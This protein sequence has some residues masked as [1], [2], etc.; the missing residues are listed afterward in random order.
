MPILAWD[1]NLS[2]GIEELDRQHRAFVEVVRKLHDVLT[3]QGVVELRKAGEQALEGVQDYM[4][5]HFPA[6]EGFMERIGFPGLEEHR[7]LHRDFAL[8][9]DEFHR[10]Y[11]EGL[12]VLNSEIMKW[13]QDWFLDHLAT[14]DR[15]YASFYRE[16]RG[17]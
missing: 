16:G 6:E 7:R 13:L 17:T 2:V 14:E 15:K 4:R 5:E 10:Q 9:F 8:Q 12:V 1:G 3:E 11:R